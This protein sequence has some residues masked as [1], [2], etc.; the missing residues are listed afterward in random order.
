MRAVEIP[1]SG[2][3]WGVGP[4]DVTPRFRQAGSAAPTTPDDTDSTRTPVGGGGSL[5]FGHGP[6]LMVRTEKIG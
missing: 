3:L 5:A 1:A 4:C 6:K 2:P